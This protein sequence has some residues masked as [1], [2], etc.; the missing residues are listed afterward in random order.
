M[1]FKSKIRRNTR[2]RISSPRGIA[3]RAAVR[4]DTFTPNVEGH[5]KPGSMNPRKVGR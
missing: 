5:H 2:R 3:Q 4:L 1:A